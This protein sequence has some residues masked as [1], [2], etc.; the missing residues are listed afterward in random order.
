MPKPDK[1]PS[2]FASLG[3]EPPLLKALRKMGWNEPSD[4][5]KAL[6]PP[7]L[8]GKD[9]LGQAR[10]GTGKTGAFS[11]PACQM[12]DPAGHLQVLCLSPTR[13]LAVQVVAEMRRIAE[14]TNLHI[15]P[16]YGG[17]RV[18]TQ[19]H[20]LGKKTQIVVG[21]PGRVMD[22]IG[23]GVL[24]FKE[25][26]L[27][28]L[29]EVDR[30]LDIGFRDD[31]RKI[32]SQIKV[33]HQTIFVSAT[34]DDEIKRLAFRHMKDPVEINVSRDEI[35]VEEIDQFYCSVERYD[36]YRLL[37]IILEEED[38]KLAIVFCN[39]K[40]QARKIAKKLHA[41]GLDA[42]EIHGDLVQQRREKVM[43]RFRRH[44]IKLL[45]ATD[46]AAR[47]IDISAISHI[48]NYDIPE[49]PQVYV[50]R[51]GRTARMGARGR[52]ITFVTREEGKQITEVEMLIN[53]I[54][55][56]RK[57][58]SFVPRPPKEEAKPAEPEKESVSRYHA[59]VATGDLDW[60]P[61]ANA[62][63]KTLGSKFRPRRK[64]R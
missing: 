43:E 6:I 21:T 20:L 39:T 37:K 26:K 36:K 60:T 52:A 18:A 11:I 33:D 54:V 42:K 27:C 17:Q 8:E 25:L 10:T 48:I 51:I 61:P 59:P 45:V 3:V 7:A 63:R 38:P 28:V 23:R 44:Q 35:T 55:E 34:L 56:E 16:V 19:I 32:L 1:T 2:P 64:R 50:H 40:A 58:D 46:L 4:I 62:P 13:E 49:D 29:D 9:L 5:Q 47:G 57:Y 22:L 15:V 14:G 41:D 30:M 12:V 24:K 53:K 31:I